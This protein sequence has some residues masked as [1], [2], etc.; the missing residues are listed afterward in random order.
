ML[1]MFNKRVKNKDYR[2][3]L[4]IFYSIIIY[5]AYGEIMYP[6]MKLNLIYTLYIKKKKYINLIIIIVH[7]KSHDVRLGVSNRLKVKI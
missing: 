4:L 1:L 7:K 2:K 5:R 3:C 6:I